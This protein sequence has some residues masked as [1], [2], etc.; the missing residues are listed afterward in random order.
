MISNVEAWLVLMDD[1]INAVVVAALRHQTR[2]GPA[3]AVA[4]GQQQVHHQA[5]ES[6]G[7]H[8]QHGFQQFRRQGLVQLPV[9]FLNLLGRGQLRRRQ[10]FLRKRGR[11]GGGV[12][13]PLA[14]TLPD[15][16]HKGRIAGSQQFV[17]DCRR[18]AGQQF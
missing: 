11:C 15:L 5:L 2:I 3:A 17:V 7:I 10:S 4:H 18:M 9:G 14:G 6:I 8:P 1:A 12:P 16:L 13:V